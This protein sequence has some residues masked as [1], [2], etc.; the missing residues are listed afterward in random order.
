MQKTNAIRAGETNARTKT[1]I[2]H[3][4]ARAQRGVLGEHVAVI[5]DDFRAIH[6][7]KPRPEAMMK[8]VQ[9]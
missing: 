7:S 9:H 5:P 8:F 4:G 2:Q 3:A 6:I 1:E